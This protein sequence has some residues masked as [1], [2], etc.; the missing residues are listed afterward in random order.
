MIYVIRARKITVQARSSC[1]YT[2][3][4]FGDQEEMTQ[5]SEYV[6]LQEWIAEDEAFAK[7][8]GTT[9]YLVHKQLLKVP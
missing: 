4:S 8:H 2:L 6:Y 3:Q 7:E 9:A 1:H 5:M